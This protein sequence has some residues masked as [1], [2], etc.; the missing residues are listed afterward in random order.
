MGLAGEG[1]QLMFAHGGEGDILHD[2]HFLVVGFVELLLQMRRR[3]LVHAR[4]DL[5]AGPGHPIG[6]VP[7]PFAIRVLADGDEEL[8]DGRFRAGHIKF[9]VCV[10][11]H[12]VP[13]LALNRRCI[14]I[15]S[16][17]QRA[18]RS[19]NHVP[20]QHCRG[21]GSHTAGNRG[22]GGHHGL[23]RGEIHVAAELAGGFVPIDAHVDN[24]LACPHSVGAHGADVPGGHHQDIRFA[25]GGGQVPG[26]G[27]AHGDGG[28]GGLQHH[29][30]RLADD[31]APAH[32]GHLR[33]REIVVVV[34]QHLHAGVGGAGREPDGPVREDA[35]QGALG[36]AVHVLLRGQRPTGSRLVQVLRQGPEHEAAVDGGIPVH[37]GDGRY[38]LFL[39]AI[40][41]HR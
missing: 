41:E 34:P 10:D 29:A 19:F 40:N 38:Q 21:D 5:R 30:H 17:G 33:T 3:I 37:G 20:G 27:V 6:G 1:Q 15:P 13:P 36:D 14:R 16:F 35:E 12:R 32:H 39:G 28:V 8:A 23:R 18:F 2:D 25:A 31:Q 7:Q 4:E 22:D 9:A 26:A 11:V 24:H